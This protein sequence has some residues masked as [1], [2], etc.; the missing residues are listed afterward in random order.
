MKGKT[1]LVL[2]MMLTW[3][4]IAWT[5]QVWAQPAND[6]LA[7]DP[8]HI[9]I[10]P[11]ITPGPGSPI[12]DL[13]DVTISLQI[14]F[15]MTL[16]ALLPSLVL[17]TTAF[18]RISIVLGMLRRAIGTQQ[19]PSNQVLLGMSLFLTIFVMAPTMQ[20]IHE[21][22]VAPYLEDPE[23]LRLKPG[24][25]NIYG[26]EVKAEVRPFVAMLQRAEVPIR[27]FMW[28]QIAKGD[29]A[30][31]VALFMHVAKLD[32]PNKPTDVPIWALIPAFMISELKKAFI[33]GFILFIPFMIVDIVV[34]SILISMGMF[35]LPP[36]FLSLPFKILLF[37]LVDGWRLVIIALGLSFVE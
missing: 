36:A 9:P 28:T 22:A 12:E 7:P 2:L 17:M 6:P 23:Q 8:S 14:L 35:Q 33:M 1:Q 4:F 26:D 16:L 3:L 24:D 32:K 10:D 15:L 5:G 18:T 20:K 30:K 19:S 13:P 34:A 11:S 29:G 25:K 31:D 27:E 21:I 37:V